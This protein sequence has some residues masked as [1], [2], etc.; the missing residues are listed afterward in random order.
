MPVL[1]IDGHR[2]RDLDHDGQLAPYEDWRLP[3]E[4]RARDL[5]KRMT[6]AEKVGLLLHG[7][8]PAT[9]EPMGV[10]GWGPEYDIEKAEALIAGRGVNSLITRLA[11]QPREL[12]AQNNAIQRIAAG[13][14]LGIPVTISTDPRHHYNPT[15]GASVAGTGFSQWPGTLGFAA[16]GESDLMVRFADVMRQEYRATG[17][18]M[19][20][21]PQADLATSP[22]WARIDGTFGEDPALVRRL[23]GDYVAGA[24]GGTTGLMENGVAAIVKH[25]VGYGASAEGFDGHNYYGRY[26]AFTGGAFPVHVMAFLD[27]FAN[28]VAGVMPTYNILRDL[29]L[30]EEIIEQ[31]GAGYSRE[32]LLD[33]LRGEHDYRG[34]ILSD[35]AIARNVNESCRTG[36]PRMR[37]A[38]IS[39]AWGVEALTLP[40]RFA[41]GIN[42]GLD[43]FGG[44][45]DPAPLLEAVAAGLLGEDRI[46]ESALRVLEQK[47]QLGLFEN[48]YVDEDVAADLVGNA[49]VLADGFTAQR[50]S[51]VIL[52][53]GDRSLLSAGDRIYLH[54][55]EATAFASAGLHVVDDVDVATVAV[56]QFATPSQRLHPNFFFGSFQKEGDL[57]FKEDDEDF[58]AFTRVSD[59]LPTIVILKMDRPPILTNLQGRAKAILAAFGVSDEALVS[60]L[61]DTRQASGRLPYALPVS[62]AAVLAQS[63][64][65]PLDD[66][67]PL[68]PLGDG[69][70]AV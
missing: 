22:R 30:N 34:L 11:L 16:L 2:F 47:F 65:K 6:L 58:R 54:G 55:L 67:S 9:G 64:D 69:L 48:P 3:N 41:K 62:M 8:L 31:V 19:A 61:V 18:H 53:G 33:L 12:A 63:P 59:R 43:Q 37:P 52:E 29:A 26:S 21:S 56:V 4:V 25:W 20:L 66:P 1:T 68:Y 49:D 35:W 60:V 32:L 51:M 38:D 10:L 50:R 27:A 28:G 23:V 24:Q 44:E 46:D 14:R 7:T 45:E 39:M 70:S 40:E 17:M 36:E 57:D 15:F 42:A 5:L 13:T